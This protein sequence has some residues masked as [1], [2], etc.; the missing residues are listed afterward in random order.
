MFTGIEG[1]Y[2]FRSKNTQPRV[3]CDPGI[4]LKD[5]PESNNNPPGSQFY[6]AIIRIVVK[7]EQVHDASLYEMFLIIF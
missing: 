5:R 2:A 3:G 7:V 6:V 1:D 4:G